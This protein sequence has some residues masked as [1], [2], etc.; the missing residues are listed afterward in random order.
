MCKKALLLIGSDSDLPVITK[1]CNILK[2]F[3][4]DFEVHVA[5]AHRTP[6][7]VT[8]LVT[9]AHKN[10]FAVIIAAAGMA[11]HLAGVVA[12][13]TVLPVIGLPCSG[14]IL[15][16]LDALLSTLQMPPGVPVAC[17]GVNAGLNAG[18]LAVQI[19]ALN[20]PRLTT[21]FF[22]YKT[23]MKNKIEEKDAELQNSLNS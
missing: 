19:L 9:N 2:E 15:D 20:S 17:V 3:N 1:T 7:K 6:E 4:V 5:S 16:G 18:L 22:E 12:G 21:Q 23:S 10:N 14:G 8:N 13:H 11:A